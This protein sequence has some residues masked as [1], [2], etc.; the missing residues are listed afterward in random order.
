[1]DSASPVSTGTVGQ[2]TADDCRV[3]LPTPMGLDFFVF[4][5]TTA[6]FG[7]HPSTSAGADAAHDDGHGRTVAP[8]DSRYRYRRQ[9]G[10]ERPRAST[11]GEGPAR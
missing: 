10:D 7:R 9:G 2:T 6:E 11:S 1:M 5:T 3:A 8:H 4:G